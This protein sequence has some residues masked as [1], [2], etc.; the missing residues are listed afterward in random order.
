MTYLQLVNAV[1]R[2]LREDEVTTV[3]ESDYS[4]LIGD[5]VNDAKRLV[6]DAWDWTAL[7]A[8]LTITTVVG[9]PTYSLTD[10]GVRSEVNTVHN[11]TDNT[12]VRLESL[13]RIREQNLGTDNANGTISYYAI[14]GLDGNDDL[15]LRLYQTPNAVK[16]LT[17]YGVKRP[18]DLSTDSDTLLVPSSPVIQWAYAYALRERGETGGESGAEQAIFAQND[19]STAISL[20]AVHHPEELIWDTV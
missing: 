5:F 13:K 3:D 14:D 10:F 11:E 12:L 8:P 17:V 1:M 7:R 20:D 4:K 15:K 19:L 6:E 2:R 16:T 18:N 9:T